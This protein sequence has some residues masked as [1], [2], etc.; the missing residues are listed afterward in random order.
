LAAHDV[1]KVN[2]KTKATT[3]PCLADNIPETMVMNFALSLDVRMAITYAELHFD[4]SRGFQP[5]DP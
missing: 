4:L 2:R 5:A 1:K 3:S